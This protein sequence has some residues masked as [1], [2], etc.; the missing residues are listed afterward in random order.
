MEESKLGIESV[1]RNIAS[2]KLI[3]KRSKQLKQASVHSRKEENQHEKGKPRKQAS[4]KAC[5]QEGHKQER[6]QTCKKSNT[7]ELRHVEKKV[8][9]QKATSTK[10]KLRCE[11]S[12]IQAM[13]YCF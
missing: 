10:G 11:S 7:Q 9:N 12:C 8:R 2:K 5:K 3:Q 6:K 1:N 13:I 4:R